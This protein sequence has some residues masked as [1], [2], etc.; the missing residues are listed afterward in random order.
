MPLWRGS[1][2]HRAERRPL[3]YY[4][5]WKEKLPVVMVELIPKTTYR[6][7]QCRGET[8]RWLYLGLDSRAQIWWRDVDTKREFTE[9]SVMYAW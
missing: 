8:R 4:A 5:A 3:L 2:L 6:I 1:R 9:S 7:E